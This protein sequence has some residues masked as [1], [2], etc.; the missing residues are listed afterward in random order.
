[1]VQKL[2]IRPACRFY[3]EVDNVTRAVF[4][5]V[6]G[7][8][9][10]VVVEDVEEGGFNSFVH[11]MPGR[12]KVGNI[13]LKRGLTNSKDFLK[14]IYDMAS[15]KITP[16]HVKVTMYN[17]DGKEA[18]HWTFNGAFPVKWSGPTFKADDTGAAIESIELAH[19]GFE[20]G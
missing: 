10:E 14:W 18:M 4:S 1:M 16:R 9:M 20:I 3:V 12:C 13:T 19:D 11:R 17:V 5:E 7:L 6:S 2:E 15:G 8:S